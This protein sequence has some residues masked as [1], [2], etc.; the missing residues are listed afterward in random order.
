MKNT[1]VIE[2]AMDNGIDL[3]HSWKSVSG[4]MK[5]GRFDYLVELKIITRKSMKACKTIEELIDLVGHPF[6]LA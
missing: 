3:L 5:S 6:Y 2:T 4:A 1:S